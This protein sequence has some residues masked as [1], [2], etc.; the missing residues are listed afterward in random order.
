M[1][2]EKYVQPL[3]SKECPPAAAAIW[4][5]HILEYG[6]VVD[7]WCIDRYLAKGGFGAV[8]RAVDC[9]DSS[10]MAAV[11]I[12]IG[13]LVNNDAHG[14][15][16]IKLEAEILKKLEGKGSPVL[17]SSGNYNGRPYLIREYLQAI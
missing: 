10:R 1:K 4:D 13:D 17:F 11:K 2:K 16:R 7:G 14:M 8:Y 9:R 15:E 5:C 12:F 3:I 6:D